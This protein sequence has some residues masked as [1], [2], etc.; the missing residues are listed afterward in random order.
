MFFAW[1]NEMPDGMWVDMRC[2]G[3]SSASYEYLG[4]GPFFNIFNMLKKEMTHTSVYIMVHHGTWFIMIWQAW[5]TECQGS[6]SFLAGIVC[7]KGAVDGCWW[8]VVRRTLRWKHPRMRPKMTRMARPRR[9]RIIL[10]A[11]RQVSGP[12]SDEYTEVI[13]FICFYR[14]ISYSI[15][16][17]YIIVI[18]WCSLYVIN[19]HYF[20]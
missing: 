18:H 15:N 4:L 8:Q 11:C 14:I 16:S 6:W 5:P 2:C 3:A 7:I 13:V 12:L 20:F 19:I 17:L 1:A 10:V 9:R